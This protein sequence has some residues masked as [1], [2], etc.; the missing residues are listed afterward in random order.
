[1]PKDRE[2]FGVDDYA[3]RAATFNVIGEMQVIRTPVCRIDDARRI[4]RSN[5]PALETGNRHPQDADGLA[6][7]LPELV[8][9]H[10]RPELDLQPLMLEVLDPPLVELAVA[11]PLRIA[12]AVIADALVGI[13]GHH[14]HDAG[15]AII[16]RPLR[17]SRDHGRVG[18]A[19]ELSD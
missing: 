5:M 18:T 1:M 7:G 19:L 17:D 13:A 3:L 8:S 15:D 12:R 9:L 2:E 11:R 6:A 10:E 14:R 16:H 4:Q